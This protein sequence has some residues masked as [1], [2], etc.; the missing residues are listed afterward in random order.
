M[1]MSANTRCSGGCRDA[2][3][4]C[5]RSGN[6]AGRGRLVN[7]TALRVDWDY[8]GA[9]CASYFQPT[10]FLFSL[11]YR[12]TWSV[13]IV[14]RLPH[15]DRR[16]DRLL[17]GYSSRSGYRGWLRGVSCGFRRFPCW[18]AVVSAI[19]RLPKTCIG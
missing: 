13:T 1:E 18:Y 2:V 7:Y 11:V 5:E 17:C 16:S 19:S 10:F 9:E 12:W 4:I 14:R 15:P 8:R 3:A 6:D